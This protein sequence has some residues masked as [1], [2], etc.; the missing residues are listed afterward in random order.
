MIKLNCLVNHCVHFGSLR[1]N[2]KELT[3]KLWLENDSG[4]KFFLLVTFI[5]VIIVV[6]VFGKFTRF[7][8]TFGG[9]FNTDNVWDEELYRCGWK[10]IVSN[11]SGWKEKLSNNK[12]CSIGHRFDNLATNADHRTW[13]VIQGI[14]LKLERN[15]FEAILSLE[16][17]A[18]QQPGHTA[19]IHT[20]KSAWINCSVY[21]CRKYVVFQTEKKFLLHNFRSKF[22]DYLYTFAQTVKRARQVP[23]SRFGT[24]LTVQMLAMPDI[25][26]YRQIF[27]LSFN[28]PFA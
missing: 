2:R 22:W 7:H 24:G 25:V 21:F 8:F 12:S 18:D 10:Y 11:P 14:C 20:P 1:F 26:L 23:R 6:A 19:L 4:F 16:L 27:N 17:K 3:Y 13:D 15:T 9:L 5:F 28:L